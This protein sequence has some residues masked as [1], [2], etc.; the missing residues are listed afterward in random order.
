MSFL[1]KNANSVFNY[2]TDMT[3]NKNTITNAPKIN[4]G[5]Y[6]IISGF[7]FSFMELI[8]NL[9]QYRPMLATRI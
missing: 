1:Y 2:I 3:Y 7:L 5:P 6:G 9:Q 8:N 4:A